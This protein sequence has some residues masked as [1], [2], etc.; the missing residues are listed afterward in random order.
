[1]SRFFQIFLC[2]IFFLLTLPQADDTRIAIKQL[3]GIVKEYGA[4]P[5]SYIDMARYYSN[6]SKFDSMNIYLDSTVMSCRDTSFFKADL[7]NNPKSYFTGTADSMRTFYW[8]LLM[9]AKK[10]SNIELYLNLAIYRYSHQP[11]AIRIRNNLSRAFQVYE[12]FRGFPQ[13][14]FTIGQTYRDLAVLDSMNLFFDSTLLYC[15][16]KHLYFTVRKCCDD[17]NYKSA[18]NDMRSNI[19]GDS[20]SISGHI[21]RVY[22][23]DTFDDNINGWPEGRFGG[24][25]FGIGGGKFVISMISPENLATAKLSIKTGDDFTAETSLKKSDGDDTLPYG[26]IWGGKRNSYYT[27]LLNGDGMF[28]VARYHNNKWTHLINW[29]ESAVIG[30][31]NA[32]NELLLQKS[33]KRLSFY[34]N[35]ELV[36]EIEY[37]VNIGNEFGFISS[38]NITFSS[39]YLAVYESY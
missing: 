14:F 34:I 11:N 22:L 6:I 24:S 36:G 26:L 1:M 13:V 7:K 15:A 2:C 31:G 18:I 19:I 12:K 32:S 37:P 9:L 27:F 33:G 3:K 28:S 10:P 8:D 16:N 30:M 5:L 17:N 38:G 25:A 23:Y 35:G 20:L 4:T 39:K 21:R 29:Q